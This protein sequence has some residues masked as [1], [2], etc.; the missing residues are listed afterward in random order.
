MIQTTDVYCRPCMNCMT[1]TQFTL[2]KKRV[3][4]WRRREAN[5]ESLFPE[6]SSMQRETLIS[7][8]CS[9]ECWE[10]LT[11]EPDAVEKAILPQS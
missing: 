1:V 5:L 8:V 10:I 9:D 7:G 3:E 4:M 6:L 11:K 2:D